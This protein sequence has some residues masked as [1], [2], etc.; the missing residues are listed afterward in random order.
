MLPLKD[1]ARGSRKR[2]GSVF[3]S[4]RG[5]ERSDMRSS[6][7]RENRRDDRRDDRR[8]MSSYNE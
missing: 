4:S 3:E 7:F 8:N 1:L 2:E 6:G 5:R